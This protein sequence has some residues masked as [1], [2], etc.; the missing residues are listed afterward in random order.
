MSSSVPR[1][2]IVQRSANART[3]HGP[4]LLWLAI[5]VNGPKQVTLVKPYC[6][7]IAFKRTELGD[8]HLLETPEEAIAAFRERAQWW[9]EC[10]LEDLGRADRDLAFTTPR[11]IESTVRYAREIKA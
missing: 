2:W 3:H 8:W 10:A 4:R 6:G 7:R 5:A 1:L 11:S 9:R